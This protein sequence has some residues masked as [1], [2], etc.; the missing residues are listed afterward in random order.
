MHCYLIY[1]NCYRNYA[2]T[3]ESQVHNSSFVIK[4][5]FNL[6]FLT[7]ESTP[8]TSRP[9]TLSLIQKK[10]RKISLNSVLSRS[11]TPTDISTGD[12]TSS[13]RTGKAQIFCEAAKSLLICHF[14][15]D[16]TW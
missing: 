3:N 8:K 13:N 9:N 11:S 10:V 7:L 16:V 15:F 14:L 1:A 12:S 2:E 4:Q 5:L 6:Y